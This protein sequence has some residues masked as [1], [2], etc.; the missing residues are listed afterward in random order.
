MASRYQRDNISAVDTFQGL[1]EI[2]FTLTKIY[3]LSKLK[4]IQ[5]YYHFY[6]IRN[7]TNI[8]LRFTWCGWKL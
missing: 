2:Y 8:N 7:F 3:N 4:Y 5:Q 1:D 6:V